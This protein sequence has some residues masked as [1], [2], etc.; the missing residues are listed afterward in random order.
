MVVMRTAATM[1]RSSSSSKP[2][3]HNFPMPY[4]KWGNQKLLRCENVISKTTAPSTNGGEEQDFNLPAEKFLAGRRRSVEGFNFSKTP[5]S[6]SNGI[7]AVRAKLMVD[8]QTAADKMKVAILGEGLVKETMSVK[9]KTALEGRP[10][11]LRTRRAAACKDP[12]GTFNGGDVRKSTFSPLR[13]E[14]NGVSAAVGEARAGEERERGKFSVSLSRGEVEED[15][16]LMA[17]HKPHRRPKKRPKIVQKQLDSLFPGLWL[18]DVTA[19]MYKVAD[20]P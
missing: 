2:P 20:A 9:E 15:F 19:D 8:L 10:W 1:N 16:M 6:S 5:T 12:I 17:G 14:N 13:T 11:N 7:E 18:T 4:L 3:L